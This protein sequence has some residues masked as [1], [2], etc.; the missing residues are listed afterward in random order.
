MNIAPLHRR[1]AFR[2]FL[3]AMVWIALY[4]W[5]YVQGG[6][7]WPGSSWLVDL[8]LAGITLVLILSLLGQF[9]LPVSTWPERRAAVRRLLAYFT[10]ERGPVTF[11]QSGRAVEGHGESNRRGA[12]VILVDHTSAAVLRTDT[13]FTR[14]VG[15]GVVFT[16]PGER[17]AEA[18]DLR[19]QIREASGVDP[20]TDEARDPQ[21]ANTQAV[22]KDG[23]PISADLSVSFALDPGHTS[24]L[25]EGR[26]PHL[27]PFEF[28]RTSAER[29]VFSHVYGEAHDV[30]W[31]ELPLRLTV[32][33]WRELVKDTQLK[34]LLGDEFPGPTALQRV[35][36][37]ILTRLTSPTFRRVDTRGDLTQDASLEYE[38]LS[39]RGI[40]VLSVSVSNLRLPSDIREERLRHW[41]ESWSGVTQDAL[42]EGES[43]VKE[44]RRRG[45]AES[46]RILARELT[47][48]LREAL[49]NGETPDQRACLLWVMQDALR[50]CSQPGT[51]VDASTLSM[52][53]RRA[54]DEISDLGE[55]PD[56]GS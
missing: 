48:S 39:K 8:C 18:L 29:A 20:G 54:I 32:D 3:G 37:Q 31:S 35:R 50:L 28:N 5:A 53:L 19:Q 25:R 22:T 4:I 42:A 46:S 10:G 7:I 38:L 24:A 47:T 6:A 51:V 9:V 44:A 15:P 56:G 40:R 11:V 49:A 41:R 26:Y 33:L 14:A 1:P 30:P 2:T 55:A 12:G 23:I 16:E 21:A 34:D 13:K 52:Q 27:P 43:G 36:D 45:E 17:L